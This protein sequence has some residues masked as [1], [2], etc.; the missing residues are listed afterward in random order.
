MPLELFI[1]LRLL[2]SYTGETGHQYV[3]MML[4]VFSLIGLIASIVFY[5][6]PKRKVN[7][8]V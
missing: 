2:D 7:V 6:I 1:S 5:R 4:S 8:P 3:F